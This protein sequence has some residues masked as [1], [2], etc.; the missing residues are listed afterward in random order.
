MASNRVGGLR[1]ARNA[2]SWWVNSLFHKPWLLLQRPHF[3]QN[4]LPSSA[5]P[6]TFLGHS[7][8]TCCM[9][10]DLQEAPSTRAPLPWPN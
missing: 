8:A 4:R 2:H 9:I 3:L 1:L 10:R 7:A 5:P 6:R